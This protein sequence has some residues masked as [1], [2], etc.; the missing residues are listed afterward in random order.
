MKH[1]EVLF[2]QDCECDMCDKHSLCVVLNTLGNDGLC[3]CM[4]C[5]E[6]IIKESK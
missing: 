2:Y 1:A 6:N 4:D 5:L 3:I